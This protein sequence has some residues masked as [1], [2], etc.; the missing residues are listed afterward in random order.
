MPKNNYSDI[1]L[2]Y[3]SLCFLTMTM[4]LCLNKLV[5]LKSVSYA[6]TMSRLILSILCIFISLS[7]AAETVYK[8]TNPDGSVEFT[9]TGSEDSE[10]VKIRKPTSYAPPRL[11]RLGLP[12]KKLKP[13]FN[14]NI[15][16]SQPAEDS[17]ITNQ[18][19]VTVVVS[20]Q[21]A[22][23]SGQGH[24]IRYDLGGQSTESQSLS[25]TFQN[26]PRGTHSLIVSIIDNKGEVVSPIISRNFHMK[27]FFKKPIP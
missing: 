12:V 13:N 8:K 10:E 18:A 9:D 24:K 7:I 19:N 11:P 21:P 1:F 22:L 15:T 20:V 25:A 2:Y 17:V 16:I 27:R 14:Y 3:S 5:Y 6:V 4:S 26:V 23:L